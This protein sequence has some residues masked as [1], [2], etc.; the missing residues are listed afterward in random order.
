MIKKIAKNTILLSVSQVISRGIGFLYF[1]FLARAL[2]VASFG[3]YTFTIAFA[4]N[5]VPVADFGIERVVLRDIARE[6]VKASYYFCRLMP[7]RLCLAVVAYLLIFV[8]AIILGRSGREIA[9]LAIFGLA[10]IPYNLA[11]LVASFLNA[12]E[13]MEYLAIANLWIIT[14]TAVLGTIFIWLKM[15]I[16]FIFLGYPLA[17][18]VLAIWFLGRANKLGL[19]SVSAWVV[20]KT[21]CLKILKDSWA[22]AVLLILAV[23]YLRLSLIMV[24]LLQGP[25]ATGLYSSAFKFIEAGIL[26]PQALA[27]AL[28]PL[29]SK[30]ISSDK[31]KL[32]G[33]YL[34][35][36]GVLLLLSS[37]FVLV[38][39]VFPEVLIKT[40]YGI[41][42]LPGLPAFKILG[43]AFVFFFLNVLPGNIIQSSDR[44]KKFLPWAAANF[45]V[46]L[47]LCVVLIPK[48]SIV[49]AAWAV[50]GGEIFGLIINN[51]FVFKILKSAN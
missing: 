10:L 48:Y 17:N 16:I 40:A 37:V 11:F 31:N 12:R 9:Y 25:V 18:L 38:F 1:I 34:K 29:S 15:G 39:T 46:L 2:G 13:K 35:G 43:L 6:P 7:L 42:Y 24:N 45:L 28:F 44:F 19:R 33:I 47:I 20:D 26:I 14:A 41:G 27:L 4:Y 5:F 49:G 21:F 36:L 3:V 51:F 22:F 8:L 32:K 50:M 23:F 30:L